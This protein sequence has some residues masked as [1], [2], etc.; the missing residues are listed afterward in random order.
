MAL[1]AYLVVRRG[2]VVRQKAMWRGSRVVITG[3]SAGLGL[4]MAEELVSL[5]AS[6]T[7]LARNQQRLDEAEAVLS[8]L[9]SNQERKDGQFVLALSTD[10]TDVASLQSARDSIVQKQQG[11]P[12]DFLICCAGVAKPGLF[13]DT[14]LDTFEQQMQVNY[15]GTVKAIKTFLPDLISCPNPSKRVVLVASA[16]SLCG[17]VGYSQYAA[18]KYALRGLA[19]CLR[20]EFLL[21]DI[22][23]SIFYASSMDS[24]GYAIEELTKPSLTRQIEGTATLF[25]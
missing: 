13:T 2:Q 25:Q 14:S 21:Y 18:T 15:L 19:E 17:F 1:V 8:Q 9:L 12:I 4:A 24:P 5:G 11:K 16:M 7:I 23:V 3:G 6:V 22:G 20:N 10:V